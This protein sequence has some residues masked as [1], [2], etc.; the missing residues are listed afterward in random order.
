MGRFNKLAHAVYDC[1]YHL[2]WCPKYR[3]RI[4]TGEVVMLARDI[5]KQ[6]CEWK[7]IEILEGNVQRD[8]IHLVLSIPPKYSVSEMIGFLKG[9]SAI[10]MFDWYLDLK[11]RYW[12]RHFW[13]KGYCVSTVGLDEE[14]IRKYVRWQLKKDKDMDQDKLLK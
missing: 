11:K 5:I 1:E 14:Q 10:K 8:H 13:A 9:K 7:K 3:F 2:V 4:L 12:G 6:L